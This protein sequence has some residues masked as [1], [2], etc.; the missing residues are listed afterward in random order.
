MGIL[1]SGFGVEE[2]GRGLRDLTAWLREKKA[3]AQG[4]RS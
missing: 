1:P 4:G 2:S 3:R